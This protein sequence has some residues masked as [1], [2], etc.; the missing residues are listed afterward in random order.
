VRDIR[1]AAPP[2]V[3]AIKAVVKDRDPDEENFQRHDERQAV[4]KCNLLAVSF[5]SVE[6]LVVRDEVLEQKGPDGND[7]RE[8]VQAAPQ[9]RVA[10]AGSQGRNAGLDSGSGGGGGWGPNRVLRGCGWKT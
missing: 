6:S 4:Q 9:E 3:D 7:A 8:R 10:D 1:V 5:R 2:D